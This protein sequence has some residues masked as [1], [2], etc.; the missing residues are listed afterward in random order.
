MNTVRWVINERDVE[1]HRRERALR[2]QYHIDTEVTRWFDKVLLEKP[3]ARM[4]FRRYEP[5][6]IP[7]HDLELEHPLTK[8]LLNVHDQI[9]C[10]FKTGNAILNDAWVINLANVKKENLMLDMFLRGFNG[11]SEQLKKSVESRMQVDVSEELVYLRK[12]LNMVQGYR[13]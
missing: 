4:V 13:S 6:S 2:K 10:E 9:I 1:K 12:C 8:Y 5:L 11:K 7:Q 3:V